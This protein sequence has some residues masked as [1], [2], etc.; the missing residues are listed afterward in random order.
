MFKKIVLMVSYVILISGCLYPYENIKVI[1]IKPFP[2]KSEKPN[3][4]LKQ[5]G[6]IGAKKTNLAKYYLLKGSQTKITS[7]VK[8]KA[9]LIKGS[10]SKQIVINIMKWEH[11]NLQYQGGAYE[12]RTRTSHEI[13]QS[14]IATGCIDFGLVFVTLARAKGISASFT[15]TVKEEWIYTMVQQ[16]K[17]IQNM[18]GHIFSEVYLPEK[19]EWIVVDPTANKI[20]QRTETGYYLLNG[21]R[22][23]LFDRGLDSWDIGLENMTQFADAVKA[24]F[25]IEGNKPKYFL[26]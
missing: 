9:K 11:N 3:S 12:K 21:K 19:K 13:I 7:L 17:W 1:H 24:R 25:Y 10:T 6:I 22:Y 26:Y 8:S 15:E 4:I 18:E 23:L 14:G 2:T 20:T 5:R 16:Q